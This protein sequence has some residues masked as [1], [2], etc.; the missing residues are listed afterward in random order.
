M[1]GIEGAKAE[2]KSIEPTPEGC[3]IDLPFEGH[4]RYSVNTDSLRPHTKYVILK[5]MNS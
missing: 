3:G 5:L 2:E 1:I 4:T